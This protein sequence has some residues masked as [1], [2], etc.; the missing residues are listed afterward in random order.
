[1][2]TLLPATYCWGLADIYL[3]SGRGSKPTVLGAEEGGGS[4]SGQVILLTLT[5]VLGVGTQLPGSSSIVT[6][7]LGEVGAFPGRHTFDLNWRLS[8]YPVAWYMLRWPGGKTSALSGRQNQPCFSCLIQV[9][10]LLKLQVILLNWWVGTLSLP[11][12]YCR[13]TLLPQGAKGI[14]SGQVILLTWT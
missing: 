6:R 12:T 13:S 1:M 2:G 3:E 11:C 14:F 7:Y 4:F 8:G 9:R 10:S 5:L